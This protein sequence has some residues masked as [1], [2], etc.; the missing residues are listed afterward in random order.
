MTPV[1]LIYQVTL[2]SG[3]RMFADGTIPAAFKVSDSVIAPNGVIHVVY[4]RAGEI[5]LGEVDK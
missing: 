5:N 2:G 1:S 4:E 3:K